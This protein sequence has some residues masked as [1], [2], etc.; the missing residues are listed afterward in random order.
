MKLCNACSIDKPFDHF[1]KDARGIGGVRAQCKECIS[2]LK[3]KRWSERTE[4]QKQKDQE[5]SKQWFANNKEQAA[6]Y[7]RTWRS[8]NKERC[9]EYQ[10]KWEQENPGARSE[11]FK[12]Y[13]KRNREKQVANARR[14]QQRHPEKVVAYVM[15][16][17]AHKRKAYALWDREFTDLVALE[18]A[19]V[20]KLR[21][22]LTGFKWHV[23]HVLPLQGKEVCGLHVWNNLQVIPAAINIS[24]GNKMIGANYGH[25]I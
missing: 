3:R 8:K 17:D 2:A 15:K 13:A 22:Q 21:E 18:A 24:K 20:A 25:I 4:E 10:K 7:L 1:Y 16:R 19:D 12:E 11:Y 6:A 23:D 14:W 9:I 5:R